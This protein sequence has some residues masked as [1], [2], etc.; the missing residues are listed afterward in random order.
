MSLFRNQDN[1]ASSALGVFG[2]T[3]DD[4]T[5]S[6]SPVVD[7]YYHSSPECFGY[8][9]CQ[10]NHRISSLEYP[11]GLTLLCHVVLFAI[12]WNQ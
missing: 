8:C 10:S 5:G 4:F 7:D 11:D 12:L 1:P 2:E 3:L 9:R 6:L